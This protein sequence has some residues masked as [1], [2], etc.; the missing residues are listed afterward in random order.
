MG[1]KVYQVLTFLFGG[2]LLL[3]LGAGAM[4]CW[5]GQEKEKAGGEVVVPTVEP[6]ETLIVEEPTLTVAPTEREEET[7]SDEEGIR[8]AMAEKHG[9]EI[10]DVIITVSKNDGVYAQGGVRF[11]GEMGGGWWL[12]YK[13]GGEWVIVQD[14]N[15]T[16][17]CETIEP[18]DFPVSMV[19][20]CV[21]ETGELVGR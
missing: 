5:Q 15:G 21:T 12:A 6:M 7:V 17:S 18:Y 9:K 13:E 2:M 14:G 19:P 11:E 20:E 8:E 3:L 16:M 4:W 10:G 1:N